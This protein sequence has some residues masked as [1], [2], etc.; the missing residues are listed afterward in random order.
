[1]ANGAA[2]GERGVG[3]RRVA[4]GL[5]AA[6]LV[7]ALVVVVTRAGRDW[8][9]VQDFAGI[10]L[11]VRDVWSSDIP[12]VGPYSRFGWNHPGPWI[13]WATAP[14][15][16]IA[17]RPAWATVVG[18]A[19][20]QAVAIVVLARTCWRRGG[21]PLTAFG[22][23]I[24]GLFYATTGPEIVLD[25][26]NPNVAVPLFV[27]FVFQLWFLSCG[28]LQVLP[29]AVIVGTLVVQAHVGYLPV[30]VAG[31]LVAAGFVGLDARA[32]ALVTG[33]WRRRVGVALAWLL[34]LWLPPL[35]EEA[36]RWPRGSLALTVRFF[37]KGSPGEAAAGPVTALR[38]VG[39]SFAVPPPWAGG[40]VPVDPI[41][42]AITPVT[43]WWWLVPLA[44]AGLAVVAVCRTR[45]RA[46]LRMVVLTGALL[47]VGVVAVAGA[48]GELRPYMFFWMVPVTLLFLGSCAQ[49]V[50][51]AAGLLDRR[52]GRALLVGLLA[53]GAVL[54]SLGLSRAVLTK[55]GDTDP[56]SSDAAALLE[57]LSAPTHPTIVRFAGSTIQGLEG[58]V[59]D[60]LDRGGAPVRVDVG[61]GFQWGYG[62][63]LTVADASEVWYVVE[64]GPY[65]SLLRDRPAARTVAATTP[66]P[67][68]D[69]QELVGL[70]RQLAASLV[71]AGRPELV[72]S[73]SS[74][75][76]AYASADVPGIDPRSAARISQLNERV[77]E[78]GRCRCAVIAF[79]PA[80]APPPGD[81]SLELPE[82]WHR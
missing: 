42:D 59:I 44:A 13:Y 28:D 46:D 54:P 67:A 14:L 82:L 11:R 15:S 27:L 21:L 18:F 23:S 12:L 47:V 45:H 7:P 56:R 74:E 22:L 40:H 77:R 57:R 78:S 68:E 43:L 62:R 16:L 52:A 26:W 6:V 66:L 20:I 37:V 53:V 65:A 60:D 25:P 30:V 73:L 63:E 4:L 19:M 36:R 1:V 80:A 34:V 29:G 72:S 50:S 70:E 8:L 81:E 64:Q 58:A 61:G 55:A 49:A 31:A 32:G 35:I 79:P 33:G 2:S 9:P 48:R 75:L 69:E 76:F 51:R 24:I 10:D 71:A 41:T 17:G 5:T 38:I 39:A 3:A